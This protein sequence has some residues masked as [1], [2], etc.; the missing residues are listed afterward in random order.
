[1]ESTISFNGQGKFYESTT[2]F[3]E[4]SSPR[5]LA[6]NDGTWTTQG[7]GSYTLTT[8]YGVSQQWMYSPSQDSIFNEK[9]PD[10]IYFRSD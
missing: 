7:S 5:S 6:P 9:D 3:I 2:Y 8:S 10:R 1:M 4:G